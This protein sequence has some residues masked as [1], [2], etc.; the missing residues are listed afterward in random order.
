MLVQGRVNGAVFA[1]FL[2]RLMHNAAQADYDYF[3]S[4]R[5]HRNRILTSRCGT[6]SSIMASVERLC[7]APPISVAS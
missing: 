2:R 5:T 1:E 6:T 3:S 4:R 7:V